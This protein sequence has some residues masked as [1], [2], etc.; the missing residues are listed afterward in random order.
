MHRFGM[1]TVAT[2]CVIGWSCFWVFGY[3]ALSGTAEQT[4]QVV[5][6]S[7]MALAGL[8][9]GLAA[10]LRICHVGEDRSHA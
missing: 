5:G 6:A 4:A 7:L 9:V 1:K 2:L 3:L 8:G 10:Y